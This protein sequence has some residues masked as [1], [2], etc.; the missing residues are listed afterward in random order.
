LEKIPSGKR[1]GFRAEL[2]EWAAREKAL[3]QACM[4]V[5]PL[6][7]LPGDYVGVQAG[8]ARHAVLRKAGK[9]AQTEF[10]KL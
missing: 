2:L 7:L 4:E 9:L 6:E 8:N 3:W 10:A 1:G 5:D